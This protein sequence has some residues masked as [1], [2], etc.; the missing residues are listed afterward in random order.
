MSRLRIG[1]AQ[2]LAMIRHAEQCLPEEGCGLLGGVA[3]DV[4]RVIP[5]ENADHSPSR[6]RMEPEAQ[7]QAMLDLE[8][9]GL[10]LLGIFH[11][12]PAGPP[13]LSMTDLAEAR[14]PECAYIVLSPDEPG[15]ALRAYRVLASSTAP[16]TLAIDGEETSQA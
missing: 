12:H 13:D 14:Y 9:S 15:W 10:D 1:A 11:S 4:L 2:R 5:V 7:I 6:Y 16:L 8:Q 3:A